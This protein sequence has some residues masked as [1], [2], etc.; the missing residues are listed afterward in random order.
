MAGI[1]LPAGS[2]DAPALGAAVELLTSHCDPDGQTSYELAAFVCAATTLVEIL[3]GGRQGP[4]IA[5][6]AAEL[7][8]TVALAAGGHEARP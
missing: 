5:I 1:E 2:G 4:M 7:A 6:P 3:A 8:A